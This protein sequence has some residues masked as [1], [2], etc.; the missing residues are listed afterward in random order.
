MSIEAM[1]QALEA[2]E[3]ASEYIQAEH[4]QRKEMY[5]PYGMVHKYSTEAQNLLD[6]KQAI[7]S[8]RQAIEQAENYQHK[9]PLGGP[10]KVFDAM[11]DAIRAG[12]DY[13]AT[14]RSYGFLERADKKT[15]DCSGAAGPSITPL[16]WHSYADKQRA[17]DKKAENAR[18][19]GLDY[20]PVPWIEN[21]TIDSTNELSK[22]TA[23]V[24][25][26]VAC[27]IDGDLYF[28]HEID[29]ED[30]AYQGHG[31]ELLYTTPPAAPVQ[32]PVALETV[33]ETIINWDEGG[34]KRSRRELARRI[35]DLYTTPQPQQ[36]PVAWVNWCAATG[37][38]SVS[39]ECES[40]LASQPLYFGITQ[41]TQNHYS[42]EIEWVGLTQEDIDI[43]F[44]DTQEGGGFN[45]F[46]RA[47][48]A[49]LRFKNT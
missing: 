26:P 23:P 41:I 43:A 19:L 25:E 29:W 14:L 24:Q 32:E 46:A 38:R 48:E 5:E 17:L 20:E 34:D 28:H 33:Y 35:V 37:N 31:V 27:V 10:A 6:N 18:E 12:D 11:A 47:I 49:K 45:E 7:E 22:P 8:L 21:M 16:N 9:N 13:H 44:D 4:D 30:L 3:N 36:E 15:I 40:E 2:L 39:F 42:N 1:K